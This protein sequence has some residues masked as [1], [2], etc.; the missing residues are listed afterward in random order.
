MTA[1]SK[2][3]AITIGVGVVSLIYGIAFAIVSATY[4]QYVDWVNRLLISGTILAVIAIGLGLYGLI[5]W[6]TR[7]H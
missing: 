5:A 6:A 1:R 3:T 4:E 7:P 2:I